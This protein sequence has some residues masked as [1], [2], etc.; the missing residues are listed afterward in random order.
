MKQKGYVLFVVMLICACISALLINTSF[1]VMND[2]KASYIFREKMEC[3]DHVIK[4]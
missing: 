3:W 1:I 2:V 4:V